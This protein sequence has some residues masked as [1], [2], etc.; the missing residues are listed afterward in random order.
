MRRFLGEPREWEMGVEV[1]VVVVVGRARD[2]AGV[3]LN[4]DGSV[5][6][7]VNNVNLDTLVGVPSGPFARLVG[8][9]KVA[10]STFSESKS[11]E[12][13]SDASR[14][15]AGAL[16]GVGFSDEALLMKTGHLLVH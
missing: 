13:R 14:R 2:W 8:K 11:S 3:N 6:G 4:V 1:V 12:R 10:G 5:L 15:L 16:D 9:S 7:V